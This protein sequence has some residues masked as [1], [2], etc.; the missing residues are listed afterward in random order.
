MRDTYSEVRHIG[1]GDAT[2]PNRTGRGNL[3]QGYYVSGLQ[4]DNLTLRK[5]ISIHCGVTRFLK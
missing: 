3:C 5:P 1:T 2:D 4:R